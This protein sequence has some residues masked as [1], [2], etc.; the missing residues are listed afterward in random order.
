MVANLTTSEYILCQNIQQRIKKLKYLFNKLNQQ[1][2]LIIDD[3]GESRWK[4]TDKII[5][6]PEH[7]E[8]FV[9]NIMTDVWSNSY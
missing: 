7:L 8:A 3:I 9:I 2:A 5:I 1:S 4:R 6:V